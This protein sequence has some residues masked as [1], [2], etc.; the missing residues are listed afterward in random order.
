MKSAA[1]IGTLLFVSFSLRAQMAEPVQWTFAAEKIASNEYKLTFTASID[2]GWYLYSQHLE[3]AHGPVKTSFTFDA[4]P[5]VQL[6]GETEE[7]GH[8][9]EIFDHNF[10]M[11]V[12]KYKGSMQF[13][14]K[15]CVNEGEAPTIKAQVTYMTCNNSSC[16]PPRDVPF[17]VELKK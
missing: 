2:A 16:M 9:E 5:G 6:N 11:L 3:G 1:F 8:K 15:V 7:V 10:N 17:N 12:A 14:Q 13:V 4:Q